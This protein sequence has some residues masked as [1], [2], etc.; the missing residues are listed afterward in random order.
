MQPATASTEISQ[1]L[2][3]QISLVSENCTA[4][5]ICVKQCG[6]LTEHGTPKEISE[7]YCSQQ[8][9]L[10]F[11]CSLCNLCTAICP[12]DV[13]PCRM[14][15]EMRRETT[16]TSG[17]IAQNYRVIR[18]YEKRGSSPRFSY[19]GFPKD[20]DTVFFPGCTLPGTRP[21]KT[22]KLFEHLRKGTPTL[23]IVLDCCTKP[24]HDLGDEQFFST[25]FH[26]LRSYLL[27]HNIKKVI[28]ACPNCYKVFKRYGDKLAATSAYEELDRDFRITTIHSDMPVTI[29]D[30]CA[31]RTEKTIHDAVRSLIVKTGLK[32]EE[33]VHTRDK[34][35]CCGEGGAVGFFKPVLAKKWSTL[36]KD[37][38]KERPMLTYCA[39]AQAVPTS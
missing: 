9:F 1:A 33:M 6:F 30:P 25:M 27:A 22:I 4:C 26:E 19:Y 8:K 13:D 36:R 34:T 38:A 23:G 24:S 17:A 5:G 14:F 16:R 12:F 18:T 35:I 21:D 2:A 37:E 11:E 28:V 32:V 10:A 7:S 3:E 20:C 39:T 31:V 15:L 29:H